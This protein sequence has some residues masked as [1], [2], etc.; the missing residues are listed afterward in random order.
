MI[1]GRAKS[2]TSPLAP[3]IDGGQ[4]QRRRPVGQRAGQ[5][6]GKLS[7]A[8]VGNLLALR[9]GVG[10]QSA[11]GQQKHGAQAKP[12]P[13]SHQQARGLAHRHGGHKDEEQ[14]QAALPAVSGA[15][16]EADQGEQREEDVDAHFHAHPTAQ[17]N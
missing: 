11:D 4:H 3:R 13:G 14:S 12:E 15:D 9:I 1:K 2:G 10:K 6:N 17:R 5:R 16:A 8:L 7:A